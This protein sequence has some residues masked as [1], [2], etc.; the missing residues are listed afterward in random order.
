MTLSCRAMLAAAMLSDAHLHGLDDPGQAAVVAWLDDLEAERVFLLGDLFHFWW[1]FRDV[2]YAEFVPTLDALARLVARGTEVSFVPGNHDFAVGPHFGHLGIQ[3]ADELDVRLAGRRFFLAHG[4]EADESTGY[5]V[6]RA[7]LRGRAFAALMAAAGPSGAR[8]I[9]HT[10][11]GTSRDLPPSPDLVARQQAWGRAKLQAGFD[12][13]VCGHTHAPELSDGP[14]G[15]FVN[16]GGFAGD[17]TWLAVEQDGT[18]DLR[19]G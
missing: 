13:V 7:V 5:R 18:L 11:A 3:V 10:L 15:T 8:R 16:L 4:D 14:D 9:G 6:T 12:V 17:R 19:R 1:G 2:V